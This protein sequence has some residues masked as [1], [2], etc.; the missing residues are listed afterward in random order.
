MLLASVAAKNFLVLGLPA[1]SADARSLQNLVAEIERAYN[2]ANTKTEMDGDV[3][4]YADVVQWQNEL[5]ES[6]ETKD[7]A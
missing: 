7:R 1:L 3:M 5:L 4:Q 6:D 2:A